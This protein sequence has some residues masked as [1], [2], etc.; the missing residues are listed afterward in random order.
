M[1]ADPHPG[2]PTHSERQRWLVAAAMHAGGAAYIAGLL[3]GA[4]VKRDG[5][6]ELIRLVRKNLDAVEAA[7]DRADAVPEPSPDGSAG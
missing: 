4:G 1:S 6:R 2:N 3:A 5:A 7:L